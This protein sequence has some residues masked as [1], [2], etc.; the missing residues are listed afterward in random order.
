MELPQ[1]HNVPADDG[2]NTK[3]TNKGGDL[4][5]ANKPRTVPQGIERMLLGDQRYKRATIRWSRQP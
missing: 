4:L 3:D 5:F 1:D 2:E